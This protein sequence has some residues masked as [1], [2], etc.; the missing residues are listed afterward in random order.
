MGDGALDSLGGFLGGSLDLLDS[1]YALDA[2]QCPPRHAGSPTTGLK[3][4]LGD[5]YGL[6]NG[7]Q[8]ELLGTD[9]RCCF[10]VLV[11]VS[12]KK[13]A[14]LVFEAL[15]CFALFSYH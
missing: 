6:K 9:A 11:V 1:L 4:A 14:P 5:L 2:P 10:V 15:L 12:L 8:P 7:P 3:A 13:L